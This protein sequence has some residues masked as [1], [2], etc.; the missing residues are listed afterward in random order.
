MALPRISGE[1]LVISNEPD[2]RFLPSGVAIL[3]VRIA[4]KSRKKDQNTGEWVDDKGFV[5]TLEIWREKAEQYADLLS[6]FT[7]VSLSN[8]DLS[9]HE[10]ETQA[11]EKRQDSVVSLG[12]GSLGIVPSN[13]QNGQG[14]SQQAQQG[15]Y[16][17]NAQQGYQQAPQQT[18]GGYQ[19]APQGQPQYQQAAPQQGQQYQQAPQQAQQ[20]VD[21]WGQPQQNTGQPG[22]APF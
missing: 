6:K 10:Y 22:G 4:A 17:Q 14:A 7:V 9:V 5:G 21:P 8:C 20:N 2:L 15:G 19:Q 3:K 11:G 1:F 12:F 18:Q 13:D 16:Q